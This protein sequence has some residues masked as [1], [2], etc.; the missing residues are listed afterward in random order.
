VAGVLTG[1]GGGSSSRSTSDPGSPNYDPAT[2]T[3]QKAGL[4]T[5]SQGQ[6]DVP[7]E[8]AQLP[9]LGFTRAFYVAKDCKG[10]KVTPNAM[11]VFQFTNV[12]DFNAGTQSVKSA[13]PKASVLPH[14]PLVIASTGPDK[15]AN[16]AAVEKQLPPSTVVTTTTG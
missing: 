4:E 11:I 10:L 16:L 1:C 6:E 9:G 3:L 12:D 13:L 7:P 5:C 14:Y 8:L 2:T 15:D